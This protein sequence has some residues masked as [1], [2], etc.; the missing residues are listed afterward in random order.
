MKKLIVVL[1]L[2]F[3]V[4]ILFAQTVQTIK[5]KITDIRNESVPGASILIKGTTQGTISDVSG[6]YTIQAG[7]QAVLVFSFVGMQTQEIAV[8]GRTT[9]DVQLTEQ[10]INMNEVVVVGYGTQKVKDLTSSISTVKSS[11][12]SKTP[13][14]Q[15]MNALQGKVA[16]LQ[17]VTNGGPG[18]APTIRI[19]G[20]GSFPGRENEA[21]LYVVDGIFFDNIDFL[22]PSDIASISVLK[23]ASAAAI[24][25]VRA[26][27][28]VV[29][30]ETKSGSYNQ[31]TEIVY[32][33]Y[34]GTQV[35]QNV[36]KM[37]NAEQFTQMANES[38]SAPD[39]SFI[40]NAMQRYGRSRV[41]PNVPDVN[42]DWY[43]EIL[44]QAMI[45]NHSLGFDGGNEKAKY[46]LGVNYFSQEG[47]LNM[48]N[49]YERLN[50]RSKIDLKATNWLTV[51][52]NFLYSN[53]LKYNDQAGAWN[54]AYFAVPILP[55]YDPQNTAAWPTNYANAQDLGYR[56]GQN[57]FPTIDF[58]EDRMKIKK[59]LANFYLEFTLIPK[60]LTFKTTYNNNYTS[61]DQRVVNLPYFI[62]NS[63]QNPDPTIT[64]T[65]SSYNNQTW[66]NILT[67]SEIFGDHN[68]TLMAGSSYKVEDYLMLTAQG[69]NFDP[70]QE[71]SWYIHQ[72]LNKP[73]DKVDDDGTIQYGM[74]Y[75][76]RI[77]YNYSDRYLLYATM[78]ADGSSKYQEKWGYFPTIG[79]GWVISEE[80]FLKNNDYIPF[81]KLRGSWGQLGNDH[82]Q[83]SDG[84][85]TTT[86]VTTTLGG[87]VTSGTVATN[88]FSSL[89]W[90]V[91]EETNV[92]FTARFFK[93]KLSTDFDY[94]IRDTKNAAIPVSIPGVGASV[95]RPVG[96]IRNKGIELALN[97]SDKINDNLSYTVGGN[98]STLKNEAI[99]LYG[100]PYIDG[101]SAEFRQRTYVGQPLMAFYG[102]Q[103]I[104][105]YQTAAECAADPIA[106]T[107]GLVPGD[108][109]YK[110]QNNDGKI[111][112]ND[113]VILG[114]YFPSFIYGFNLSVT[115]KDFDLSAN[116]YGQNGN[117]VLNRKRGEV[118]WT[119]DGNMDADLAVN[120]WHG[121]GTSNKYP[122][123]SGLRRGWNQKM[124][125]Y[126]VEDGSFFRVQNVQLG[127][128]LKNKDWLD[129]NFPV[130]RISFTAERPLT[131][132]K[133]NGF[134]PE[135]ANGIDSQTYPIPAVYTIGLNVK[136]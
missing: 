53:A 65:I 15:P 8:N 27:N 86:V 41:N 94:Y 82:I 87:I 63:F 70:N 119:A 74:S 45:H 31:K 124:S 57:P 112:D 72:S 35:A 47:L 98:F 78:R 62:G 10:T 26:A 84:A 116:M 122:S 114:S 95:L 36:V 118:I 126:F 110:D 109:K 93:N 19:R 12:L 75:F 115:Y 30:I 2:L 3:S 20:I 121:E 67:L 117:K 100:Q 23:D 32:D 92:G 131:I 125:D 120:R 4:S 61:I 90:E 42:T 111:D 38:G 16:G 48:K 43:K 66:D 134:T 1:N 59:M 13:A 83:A 39:V 136:F 68:V 113:R 73:S 37:A 128:T 52:G 29:L 104:G 89:K 77:A 123:S 11:E 91:T 108:L 79:A 96:T 58:N 129:G 135:V 33:G 21:P 99:D 127:Y 81:L 34:I 106:V 132:F 9:I 69:K 54:Q 28:G 101:G 60:Q 102:R 40:D 85:R 17:V 71:Q 88:Y 18:N 5:G 97:W 130:C 50:L 14:S 24:Y 80:S 55:V 25:G 107:N 44:R 103:V 56:S 76:G 133:Y 64:R 46:S 7:P 22:N 105:V 51:G 49:Q 6:Q